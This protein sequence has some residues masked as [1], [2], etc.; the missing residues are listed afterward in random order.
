VNDVR[1]LIY[2]VAVG[3]AYRDI[4][5][6][7]ISTLRGVGKYDGKILVFSDDIGGMDGVDEEVKLPAEDL[8]VGHPNLLRWLAARY[9]KAEDYD[10]IMYLDVDILCQRPIDPVWCA[11]GCL[12]YAVETNF[13]IEWPTVNKILM[14]D[15]EAEGKPVINSG[16]FVID[17]KYFHAFCDVVWMVIQRALEANPKYKNDQ[18][19]FNKVIYCGLAGSVCPHRS[20][21]PGCFNFSCGTKRFTDAIFWHYNRH[22]DEMRARFTGKGEFVPQHGEGMAFNAGVLK[23]PY[24]WLVADRVRIF[25]GRNDVILRRF[26]NAWNE[27]YRNA[28]HGMIGMQDVR[29]MDMPNGKVLAYG[30][31]AVDP[32]GAGRV[33]T[34]ALRIEDT[35]E[36]LDGPRIILHHDFPSMDKEK[37]WQLFLH[38]GQ[39]FASY[40][41]VPHLVLSVDVMTGACRRRYISSAEGWEWEWGEVRGG[42]PWLPI[43]NGLMI[44]A[45][46]SLLRKEK[47]EAKDPRRKVAN[48]CLHYFA[49]WLLAEAKP[50]FNIIAKSHSPID[51]PLVLTDKSEHLVAFPMS[52]WRDGEDIAMAY[53]ENDLR[54][55]IAKF[56]LQE[57]LDMLVPMKTAAA[58]RGAWRG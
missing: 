42:T 12:R 4:A 1:K 2:M 21:P 39:W 24:G 13:I 50:P 14:T 40:G 3:A 23:R 46:H 32:G 52:L 18:S 25:K 6:M 10:Q 49:G 17:A 55:R 20:L 38:E 53:G 30:S 37:N 27:I 41:L 45:F 26:D 43:G 36:C 54:T 22:C 35:S 33:C 8:K 48:K 11:Q 56:N 34:A 19:A 28:P 5:S 16:Q 9:I 58:P 51:F 57:I 47:G 15:E 31:L 44:S 29:L 7:L